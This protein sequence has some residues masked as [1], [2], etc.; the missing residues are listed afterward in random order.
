MVKSWGSHTSMS[1]HD[2]GEA[3]CSAEGLEGGKFSM[4]AS[5]PVMPEDP[6]CGWKSLSSTASVIQ[7]P[8]PPEK[9][10]AAPTTHPLLLHSLASR[11]GNE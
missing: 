11:L 1:F 8:A 5:H 6:A 2:T 3:E 10:E 9:G 7:K 4:Q